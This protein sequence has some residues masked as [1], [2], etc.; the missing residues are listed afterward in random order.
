MRKRVKVLPG[1]LQKEQSMDEMMK[2]VQKQME[3][4]SPEDKKIME[5]MGVF[6]MM[7]NVENVTKGVDMKQAMAAAEADA[8]TKMVPKKPSTLAIP[9]TPAGK[10]QLKAYLQS[11]LQSTEAAM[12]PESKAE[13]KKYINKGA[14][15]G[16]TAMGFILKSE[17]DKSLYLL[18]NAG[19]ANP[20]DYASLNNLSA[21]ITMAGYA[22]KSLPILQYVQKQFP[23]SKGGL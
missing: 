7:K 9:S 23:Q 16:Q 4:M 21:L 3:S 17:W 8:Q 12:K 2:E 5:D 13:A 22:H 15:T 20:E 11:M 6:D 18:L 19:I 1:T 14:E 10:E